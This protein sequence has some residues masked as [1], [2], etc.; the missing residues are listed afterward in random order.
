MYVLYLYILVGSIIKL[1]ILR[2]YFFK[3]CPV[4]LCLPTADGVEGTEYV[5]S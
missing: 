2:T 4:Y 1:Y 3:V 5:G